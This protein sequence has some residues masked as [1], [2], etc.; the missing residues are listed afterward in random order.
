MVKSIFD[1]YKQQLLG[2]IDHM[3]VGFLMTLINKP[4]NLN[5]KTID[6]LRIMIVDETSNIK[7]KIMELL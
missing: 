7:L 3:K 1:E 2:V 6:K 4:E 5:Y